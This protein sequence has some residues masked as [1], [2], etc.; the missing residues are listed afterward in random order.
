M[1]QWHDWARCCVRQRTIGSAIAGGCVI[2]RS[3]DGDGGC[4]SANRIVGGANIVELRQQIHEE[5]LGAAMEFLERVRHKTK[6]AIHFL[7]SEMAPPKQAS[8]S[9]L[10]AGVLK[11]TGKVVPP[12]LAHMYVRSGVIDAQGNPIQRR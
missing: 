8:P 11:A 1:H 3:S 4:R 10:A 9:V 6:S 5:A 2:G 12:A 7:P